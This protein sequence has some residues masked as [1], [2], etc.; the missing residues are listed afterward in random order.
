[1]GILG[2][3]WGHSQGNAY[4]HL[5]GI[6]SKPRAASLGCFAKSLIGIS[7]VESRPTGVKQWWHNTNKPAW[8][9][10]T[11]SLCSSKAQAGQD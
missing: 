9:C 2:A 7:E 10:I 4:L 11:G 8:I 5:P 3:F 6:W 1:M